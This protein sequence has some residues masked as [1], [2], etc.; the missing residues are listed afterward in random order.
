MDDGIALEIERRNDGEFVHT[1]SPTLC[2]LLRSR[3]FHAPCLP[4][5]A[6][7]IRPAQA[8][9]ERRKRTKWP[10]SWVGIWEVPISSLLGS[11]QGARSAWRRSPGL[12]AKTGASLTA[13]SR[14]HAT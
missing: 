2:W 8:Q 12:Y 14:R 1:I 13:H 11:R 6:L 4:L 7:R 5:N 10:A 3:D 9:P